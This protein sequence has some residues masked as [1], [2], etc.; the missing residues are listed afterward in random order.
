[1]TPAQASSAR[2]GVAAARC[3]H[4]RGM[5]ETWFWCLQHGRA[6]RASE[7]CAAVQRLGPYPSREAAE[8][9]AE[10]AASRSQAWDEADERWRE[11]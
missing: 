6:E 2:A 11:G 10:T 3:G 8:S 5:T 7:G 1:M 4:V 9:F